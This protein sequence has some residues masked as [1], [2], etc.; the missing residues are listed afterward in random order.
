ML[1][2]FAFPLINFSFPLSFLGIANEN[3]GITF[4]PVQVNVGGQA[5]PLP[6]SI[7]PLSAQSLAGTLSTQQ[8][9][10]A[11][12]HL[13]GQV[14][15]QQ[16]AL[17]GDQRAKQPQGGSCA[18]S[19]KAGSLSLFFRKVSPA[20]GKSL[21]CYIVTVSESGHK[22]KRECSSSPLEYRALPSGSSKSAPFSVSVNFSLG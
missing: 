5:Q 22:G 6:S 20:H 4:I 12:L 19:R 11:A 10:G 1:Q 9:A 16:I 2:K 15:V 14:A 18:K 8:M 3:G 21:C 7:Q 17:P 13:Q